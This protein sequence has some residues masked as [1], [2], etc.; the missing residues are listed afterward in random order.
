MFGRREERRRIP[1]VWCVRGVDELIVT[2]VVEEEG[3][4]WFIWKCSQMVNGQNGVGLVV[5]VVLVT[6][7]VALVLENIGILWAS[8]S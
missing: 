8:I 1:R 7:L 6:A 2:N 3:Q 5:E 4:T